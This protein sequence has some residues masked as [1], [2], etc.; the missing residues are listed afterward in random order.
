MAIKELYVMAVINNMQI[1]SHYI[2]NVKSCL[3]IY[4]YFKKKYNSRRIVIEH[5][6]DINLVDEKLEKI[7]NWKNTSLF[8]YVHL[9]S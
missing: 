4:R 5:H 7:I 9:Y 2:E 6:R 3:D 1:T 8:L